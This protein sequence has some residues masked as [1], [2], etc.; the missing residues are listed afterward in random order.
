MDSMTKNEAEKR[1]DELERNAAHVL[2]LLE[3][4]LGR[5]R[6]CITNGVTLFCVTHGRMLTECV[7]ERRR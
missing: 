2:T 5:P 7:A 3:V 4:S 1:I 6:K